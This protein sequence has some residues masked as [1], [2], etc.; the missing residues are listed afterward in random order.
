MLI[1]DV[2]FV[3]VRKKRCLLCRQLKS[4]LVGRGVVKIV[5][6]VMVK[7]DKGFIRVCSGD[8]DWGNRGPFCSCKTKEVHVNTCKTK[9]WVFITPCLVVL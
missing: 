1:K 4:V 9:S 7:G 5:R 2:Y 6:L 3:F 8:C